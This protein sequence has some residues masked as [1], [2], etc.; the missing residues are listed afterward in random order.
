MG[1]NDSP[2]IL[3]FLLRLPLAEIIFDTGMN[4]EMASL[5]VL[6]KVELSVLAVLCSMSTFQPRFRDPYLRP[7]RAATFGSLA[8]FTMVPVLHGI[9]K[10]S[11]QVQSQRMGVVWVLVT[12]AL[13][14]SGATAYAFKVCD[15]LMVAEER[16]LEMADFKPRC[17]RGGARG[18]S[19]S[20]VRAIRSSI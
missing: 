12:L 13:N 4:P 1:R 10:Y 18:D 20:L 9:S 16:D 8:I 3:W 7:V 5:N 11:W 14:I 17:L 6:T 2:A 15:R 19:I